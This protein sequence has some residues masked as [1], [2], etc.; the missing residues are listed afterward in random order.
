MILVLLQPAHNNHSHDPLDPAHPDRDATTVN[1]V[2]AGLV[3]AH[4]KLGREGVLVPRVLEVQ[5]PGAA[6]PAEDRAAL[7]L[8][9]DLIV[10]L[11]AGARGHLEDGQAVGEGDRD[12]G[13]ARLGSEAG[14][15]EEAKIRGVDRGKGIECER[16][17]SG[18]ETVELKV[19]AV[20]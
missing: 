19:C 20:R 1:G 12:K 13:G 7:P 16:V 5:R 14:V 17:T 11:H 4:A 8:Y 10:G 2:S 15:E 18:Y 3:P 9:P 6:S